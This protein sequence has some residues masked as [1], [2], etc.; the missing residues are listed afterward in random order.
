MNSNAIGGLFFILF[1]LA[2][3]AFM[4]F[5]AGTIFRK[6][7]Y[8]FWFGLLMLVPLA[9]I[10]WLLIFAFSEWPVHRELN[11]LRSL[12]GNYPG[13]GFPVATAQAPTS[14]Q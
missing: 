3:W 10:I 14:A 13:R 4:V 5:V 1:V 8:S 12:T 9:N 2:M 11:H 7:G 6:A